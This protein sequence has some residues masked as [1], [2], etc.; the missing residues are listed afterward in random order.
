[1][2]IQSNNML[3]KCCEF[4]FMLYPSLGVF[5]VI[6]YS[7]CIKILKYLCGFKPLKTSEYT[8]QSISTKYST[9]NICSCS[10]K[11]KEAIFFVCSTKLFIDNTASNYSIKQTHNNT[12]N[13]SKS[14]YISSF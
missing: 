10:T 9:Y 6:M 5:F 13:A 8:K 2:L 7:Q 12:S 3:N 4:S 1:G 14:S 11:V